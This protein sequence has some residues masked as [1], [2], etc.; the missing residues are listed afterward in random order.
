MK[1][2]DADKD[3]GGIF[4]KKPQFYY[5]YFHFEH[6]KHKKNPAR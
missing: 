1:G 2:K 4:V 5:L 3:K 6:V